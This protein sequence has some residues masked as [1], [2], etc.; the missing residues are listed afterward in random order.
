MNAGAPILAG[1]LVAATTEAPSLG[2]AAALFLVQALVIAGAAPPL[3]GR[4][5][6]GAVAAE[7]ARG[8][9]YVRD[10]RSCGPP[11][12]AGARLRARTTVVPIEVV[13]AK[14]NLGVG[15][16]GFGV[17]RRLGRRHGRRQPRVRPRAERPILVLVAAA[18]LAIGVGYVGLAAAPPSSLACI[19]AVLGGIGNGV[20]WVAVVTAVQEATAERSRRTSPASWRP[21]H[22][23]A[24]PR[25]HPRRCADR[26]SPMRG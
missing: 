12:C 2:I 8:L 15:D 24:R 4:D 3:A 1:V 22:R 21:R 6:A 23:R 5:R 20:Q 13:Y 9:R 17:A 14:E 10:H 19:G 11:R 7:P 26:R 18:P 16:V 25:L